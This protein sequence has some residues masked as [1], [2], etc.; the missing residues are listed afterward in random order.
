MFK[1]GNSP[2]LSVDRIGGDRAANTSAITPRSTRVN[3]GG[4]GGSM[5]FEVGAGDGCGGDGGG[6]S[7][8]V[9]QPLSPL[10]LGVGQRV[11]L[12]KRSMTVC[13]WDETAH[14]W[15]ENMTGEDRSVGE[16]E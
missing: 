3:S 5:G 12:M 11:L 13:G 6:D 2:S 7:D 4:S 8:G 16:R 10:D 15:W 14:V 1:G 9:G